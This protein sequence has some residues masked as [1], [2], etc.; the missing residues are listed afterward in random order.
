MAGTISDLT[1]K[2]KEALRLLLAGHDAKSSAARLDISVHTINDRLRNARRKLG[3]SSSREAARILGVAEVGAGGSAPQS[4]AHNPLGM[5]ANNLA[6][7]IAGLATTRRAPI[8]RTAWLTGGMLIMSILISVAVVSL[9][10]TP[11][12]SIG[13]TPS[14]T[15][16][17][18]PASVSAPAKPAA[19]QEDNSESLGSARS[20]LTHLDSGDWA[21][22]WEA[23]GAFFRT[24][25]SQS[26]WIAQAMA[27]RE[28]LGTVLDRDVQLVMRTGE[29]PGAPPGEYEILEFS[30]NF[31]NRSGA[32]ERVIMR[33]SGDDWELAGY[34][35]R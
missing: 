7:D 31:A 27:A 23:S 8:S 26:Q 14:V 24:Q 9:M 25:I 19:G 30:T 32:V 35:I 5:A 21:G 6:A 1:V 13:P 34:F 16:T 15:S 11:S 12:G 20:W 29:L 17:S 3:V 18:A 33:H 4:D 10:V 22:S 28:P 2:E